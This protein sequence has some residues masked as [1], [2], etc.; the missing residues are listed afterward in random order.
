M[1]G[2]K[3]WRGSCGVVV[4]ALACATCP[5][6]RLGAQSPGTPSAE[7]ASDS[8]RCW[9]KSAKDAVL[10][11]E[12]FT[13]VLTCGVLETSRVRTV[14]DAKQF[15]ATALPL[16]PF[17]VLG[18]TPHDD[19]Q[20]PPWRYFQHE[21]TL[22]LLG[23][24]FFG[25]DV[26][27]PA[28]KI[29]YGMRL[30]STGEAEGRDQT[31]VL[32]ALPMRV[33]SVVPRNA[34]NIRDEPNETFGDIEARLGRARSALTA[35]GIFF[36]FTLV[37]L[38]LAVRQMVGRYHERAPARKRPLPAKAV[39]RG[40]FRAIGLLQSDVAREGWTEEIVG[41]A[42]ALLRIAGAVATGRP[43]AQRT[44]E[45]NVE[46]QAGQ[47]VVDGRML[48]RRRTLVSAATTAD[49]IARQ[50][51][52]GEART[53]EVRTALEQIR[54]S[55][56][57]FNAA[58]YS[59][60]GHL[61]TTALDAALADGTSALRRLRVSTRWPVRAADALSPSTSRRRVAMWSR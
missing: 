28:L 27:I 33:H 7:T 32:P 17:E 58:H 48:P 21:Y 53:P 13:L 36:G 43:V 19:I 1:T 50:L 55:L 15:Q 12:Q 26:D 20:S 2:A 9:W 4:T 52:T 3:W 56:R 39:L 41:R 60:N 51:A 31:I 54:D 49:A 18:S 8:I 47:L 59:R 23:E 29:T 22:R 46:G 5:G 44:V 57:V 37:L 34:R 10:V 42:L 25:Q 61:D 30:A 45:T 6:G 35:A 38:G 14:A 16:A 24:E 11:G 40:C